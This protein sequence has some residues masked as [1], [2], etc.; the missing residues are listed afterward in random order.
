[1]SKQT[2]ADLYD[3]PEGG[4][5]T[6]IPADTEPAADE[7]RVMTFSRD[8]AEIDSADI[9]RPWLKLAQGLTPEVSEGKA[10]VGKYFINGKNYP[11]VTIIP[12]GHQKSS[13]IDEKTNKPFE[14]F[15]YEVFVVEAGCIANI[16][17]SNS[18]L[19]AAREINGIA[20]RSGGYGNFAV[21]LGTKDQNN[22]FGSWK[23]PT[24]M[25]ADITAESL[26]AAMA[27]KF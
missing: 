21:T 19:P 14:A 10:Q 5:V 22:K 1:M 24:V 17:F 7:P 2:A 6:T 12:R 27:A 26:A 20:L 13:G 15:T 4:D 9:A 23:T 18:S 3:G 11:Q 25:Q 16:R 8:V